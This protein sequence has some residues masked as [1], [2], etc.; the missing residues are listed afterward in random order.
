MCTV[1]RQPLV[2]IVI[3]TPNV[4][5]GRSDADDADSKDR[6]LDNPKPNGTVRDGKKLYN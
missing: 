6:L 1:L 4:A 3:T 2:W 5:C